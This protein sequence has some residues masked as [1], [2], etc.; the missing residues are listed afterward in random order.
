[1]YLPGVPWA[2]RRFGGYVRSARFPDDGG[3]H[4]ILVY[5]S[6]AIPIQDRLGKLLHLSTGSF[7]FRGGRSIIYI[8]Q[9][10]PSDGALG[11][12]HAGPGPG[13]T[14]RFAK[15]LEWV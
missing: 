5:V 15:D 9:L 4:Y 8:F 3:Q 13:G 2:E 1:M 14:N 10:D 12:G 6:K 11:A 7:G